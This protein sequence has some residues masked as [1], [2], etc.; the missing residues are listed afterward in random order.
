MRRRPLG[1]YIEVPT[2]AIAKSVAEMVY[3]GSQT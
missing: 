2:P 3:P 1:L